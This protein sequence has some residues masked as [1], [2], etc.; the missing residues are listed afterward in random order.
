MGVH[1][2]LLAP[3]DVNIVITLSM[4]GSKVKTLIRHQTLHLFMVKNLKR[5][6]FIS[7]ESILNT[8]SMSRMIFID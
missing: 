1:A 3:N 2:K 5:D 4:T 7:V 6:E 8:R